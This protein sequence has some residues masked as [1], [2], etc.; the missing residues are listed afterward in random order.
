[1]KASL[2]ALVMLPSAGLGSLATAADAQRDVRVVV[3]TPRND[4]GHIICSLFDSEEEL[5]VTYVLRVVT[6]SRAC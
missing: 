6:H 1:M 3:A 4:R 5:P 2:L